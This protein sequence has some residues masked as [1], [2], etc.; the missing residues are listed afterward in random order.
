[1][2]SPPLCWLEAV[3][4]LKSEVTPVAKV[5]IWNRPNILQNEMSQR[6]KVLD[7]VLIFG[8]AIFLSPPLLEPVH[9]SRVSI[10]VSG[11]SNYLELLEKVTK[12]DFPKG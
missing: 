5:A 9:G 8:E 10:H 12:H 7:T 2:S 3:C 1:M 6:A 11:Q 4:E